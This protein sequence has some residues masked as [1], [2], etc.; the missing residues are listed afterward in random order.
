MSVRGGVPGLGGRGPSYFRACGTNFV[1]HE[2][3][4]PPDVT[5][6]LTLTV[7]PGV[8]AEIKYGTVALPFTL[9]TD[10]RTVFVVLYLAVAVTPA[11]A[12][13]ETRT[14]VAEYC[15]GLALLMDARHARGAAKAFGASS[16]ALTELKPRL[17]TIT[18]ATRRPEPGLLGTWR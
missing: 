7:N 11:R 9:A 2:A 13:V 10:L 17:S 15:F 8:A 4:L 16:A 6:T 18:K 14:L 5:T 3:F 1:E 12:T